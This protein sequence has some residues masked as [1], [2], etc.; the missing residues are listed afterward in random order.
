[1]KTGPIIFPS[2]VICLTEDGEEMEGKER[3]SWKNHSLPADL[4]F[5]RRSSILGAPL[6]LVL[7]PTGQLRPSAAGNK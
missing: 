7:L 6:N 3:E 5:T 1:M 4:S 2:H